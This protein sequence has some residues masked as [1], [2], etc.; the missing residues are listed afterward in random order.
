MNE[1][2]LCGQCGDKAPQIYLCSRG[3][4]G[5]S[6]APTCISLSSSL[7]EIF[8][9]NFTYVF[10]FV[11][12]VRSLEVQVGTKHL[13]SIVGVVVTFYRTG[14][15]EFLGP[16]SMLM[17]ASYCMIPVSIGRHLRHSLY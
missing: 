16:Q 8:S 11:S 9:P 17:S 3:T 1:S 15:T 5:C 10:I 13:R 12:I 2:L 7:W 14:G 4:G 6:A